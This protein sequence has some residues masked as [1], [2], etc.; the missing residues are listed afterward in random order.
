MIVGAL[1]LGGSHVSAASVDL[2]TERVDDVCRLALDPGGTRSELLGPILDAARSIVAEVTH[3]GVAVPGPFDYAGGIC[4]IRG[5][6]KLEGLFGVD[7]RFELS[8]VLPRTDGRRIRFL[9]DA[10]AFLLGEAYAGAARGQARAIGITLGTGLGSAFLAD[11]EIVRDGPGVPPGGNLHLLPFHGGKAEDVLSG[12]GIRTRFDG[13][14]SV[15]QIASLADRGEP[16]ARAVF[17]AF[18]SDLAEFLAPPC[19]DFRASS[20]VVG[21]S[22]ARAWPHFGPMLS[23]SLDSMVAVAERLDHA[24]LLGAAIEASR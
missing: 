5:V 10:E 4:T 6:G 21:G 12:R 15:E 23:R 24:A 13:G 9:N 16:R 18:G 20:I 22:I 19:R 2:A 3:V 1:E 11:G 17:A 7:M 14:T 8:R